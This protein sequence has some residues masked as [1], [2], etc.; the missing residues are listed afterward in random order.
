M[1]DTSKIPVAILALLNADTGAGGVMTLLPDGC[2]MNTAPPG[3]TRFGIVR[4][5]SGHDEPQFQGRSFESLVYLVKAVHQSTSRVTVNAAA[6]RIDALL[7]FKTLNVAGYSHVWVKR[8]EPV[9]YDDPD[10]V[11]PALVFQHCGGLYEIFAS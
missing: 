7:D 11:E 1:A 4:L 9:E 6:A 2:W 3:K 10:E 8:A 5:A